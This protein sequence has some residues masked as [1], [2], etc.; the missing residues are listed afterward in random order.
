MMKCD[1][2][3]PDN[4]YTRVSIPMTNC[5]WRVNR[6]PQTL[7]YFDFSESTVIP[8]SVKL[9]FN[10]F[11]ERIVKV[12][13]DKKAPFSWLPLVAFVYT[14]ILTVFLDDSGKEI[15]QEF[16]YRVVRGDFTPEQIM[17]KKVMDFNWLVPFEKNP[18]IV[19]EGVAGNAN[20]AGTYVDLEKIEN[21]N[22]LTSPLPILRQQY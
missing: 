15:K 1:A 17:R 7:E 18:L 16:S 19:F 14:Q 2:A 5:K 3:Y 22:K 8:D 9:T 6:Y 13:S 21:H 20:D 11:V 12:N 10:G 4:F